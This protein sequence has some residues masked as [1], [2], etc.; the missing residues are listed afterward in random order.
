MH[1]QLFLNIFLDLYI[2]NN[3]K[4]K[5]INDIYYN[6]NLL[7]NDVIKLKEDNKKHSEL[8]NILFDEIKNIRKENTL[9]KNELNKLNA[10][11]NR[12]E[13][14]RLLNNDDNNM[15]SYAE[16]NNLFYEPDDRMVENNINN[17]T[18]PS[19]KSSITLIKDAYA[20]YEMDSTFIAFNSFHGIAHIVYAKENNSIINYNLTEQNIIAEIKNAH[21][22]MI[23]SFNYYL[24]KIY[25]K[26]L[27]MSISAE[28]CNIKLWNLINWECISYFQNI[29]LVGCIFSSCFLKDNNNIYIVT[30][31]CADSSGP[32]KIYNFKEE[33]IKTI[34]NSKEETYFIDVYYEKKDDKIYIITGNKG[35]A[36]SY[37]Y[38]NN[39]LY[40][41]YYDRDLSKSHDSILVSECE[42][43]KENLYLIDSCENGFITIWNFHNGAVLRKINIGYNYLEGICLWNKK[44]LFAGSGDNSIKLIEIKK[45]LIIKSLVGH[46]EKV[47]SIKK[48]ENKKYGECLIS[49]GNDGNIK[50]W[51]NEI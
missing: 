23:T 38:H 16:N 46:S 39:K 28:D 24:D 37:D 33:I 18:T 15:D 11:Y 42:E 19:F 29:Y 22:K 48:I 7:Q 21:E 35:Y 26:D 51:I 49:Q 3:E 20:Y 25:K 5:I 13:G 9:L 12:K 14:M 41:K 17:K 2:R 6:Y 43:N 40:N 4:E 47:L 44:Y 45:G 34:N 50:L 1:H 31:N 27:V 10:V 8:L 32:I 36:K 30:S